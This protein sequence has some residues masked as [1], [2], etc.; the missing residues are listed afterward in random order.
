MSRN[1][2]ICSCLKIFRQL[3]EL[4]AMLQHHITN[5]HQ[6]PHA[7]QAHRTTINA[8]KLNHIWLVRPFV[9]ISFA[10]TSSIQ[11]LIWKLS[12]IY[13]NKIT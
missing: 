13:G 1:K 4:E 10:M 7:A 9:G 6:E 11:Q 2:V 3:V 12:A 8:T 5:E